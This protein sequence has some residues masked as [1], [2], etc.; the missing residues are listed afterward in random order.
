MS[1][2]PPIADINGQGAGCPFLT[3]SGHRGLTQNGVAMALSIQ[4]AAPD[5]GRQH[6][7]F[8]KCVDHPMHGAPTRAMTRYDDLKVELF[9]IAHS[10]WNDRFEDLSRQMKSAHHS[11][12]RRWRK[13][14]ALVK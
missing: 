1:A 7:R 10:L 14:A 12:K 8:P 4:M 2:L 5:G 3:Q 11:K 6:N 13:G 9:K